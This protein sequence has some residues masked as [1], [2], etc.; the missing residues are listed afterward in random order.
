MHL[1][2]DDVTPASH[3]LVEQVRIVGLHQLEATLQVDVHPAGNVRESFG[4][5]ASAV[6]KPSIDRR[7][8]AVLE[9]FDHHEQVAHIDPV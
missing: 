1:E 8:V 9:M 5:L 4:R 2:V 7:R 3:P 6:P